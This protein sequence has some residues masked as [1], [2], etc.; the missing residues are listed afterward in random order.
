M[1]SPGMASPS[2]N[3]D[4][5]GAFG[6]FPP[7]G[8]D[9]NVGDERVRVGAVGAT[10][11]DV[12]QRHEVLK[13]IE[14]VARSWLALSLSQAPL[15]ASAL[16]QVYLSG[17]TSLA[18]H[19]SACSQDEDAEPH[20]GDE[21]TLRSYA[22]NLIQE[23]ITGV[24][25]SPAADLSGQGNGKN[26]A[27]IGRARGSIMWRYW[28][29]WAMH[30]GVDL[31]SIMKGSNFKERVNGMARVVLAERPGERE[32]R[33]VQ[34]S[35]ARAAERR[36]QREREA[37]RR[38]DA[39]ENKRLE[40]VRLR[41]LA[42]E[43][44][45]ARA[46]L[47]ARERA[48]PV[49]V[50]DKGRY[51][52]LQHKRAEVV[53][54]EFT[55]LGDLNGCGD[56]QGGE[57]ADSDDPASGE[58]EEEAEVGE[59]EAEAW[60]REL[61]EVVELAH[62]SLRRLEASVQAVHCPQPGHAR[63]H[64]RP[65]SRHDTHGSSPAQ[66]S[67]SSP[68]QPSA[69]SAE[70]G[71]NTVVAMVVEDMGVLAAVILRVLDAMTNRQ[72][73]STGG[74]GGGG[75]GNT[76]SLAHG[77]D[78]VACHFGA[79]WAD[80]EGTCEDQ[81]IGDMRG[82]QGLE[83][84]LEA[85]KASNCS[86]AWQNGVMADQVTEAGAEAM[87][88]VKATEFVHAGLACLVGSVFDS[89][90]ACP[91]VGVRAMREASE[92]WA[93]LCVSGPC[94]VS[95]ALVHLVLVHKEHAL[96]A[97]SGIFCQPR[98]KAQEE[99]ED[100][101]EKDGIQEGVIDAQCCVQGLCAEFLQEACRYHL[102]TWRGAQMV[103]E[104]HDCLCIALSRPWHAG[105]TAS[106]IVPAIQIVRLAVAISQH[107]A[108]ALGQGGPPQASLLA[109]R[110]ITAA[111]WLFGDAPSWSSGVGCAEESLVAG[112]VRSRGS[113]ALL[114]N[115]VGGGGRGAS[116]AWV[117]GVG[118]AS[119]QGTRVYLLIQLGLCVQLILRAP[120]PESLFA[121]VN[122]QWGAQ[123]GVADK[124][125]DAGEQREAWTVT[126]T[127]SSMGDLTNLVS[128]ELEDLTRMT[129]LSAD[130][131]VSQDG[132]MSSSHL[133]PKLHSGTVG[134][135]S[136]AA[137]G[138]EG[139]LRDGLSKG[140][141]SG[142]GSAGAGGL[143]EDVGAKDLAAWDSLDLEDKVRA[144]A[145]LLLVVLASEVRRCFVWQN[146]RRVSMESSLI[147]R[148]FS[149]E[150]CQEM[151]KRST[152]AIHVQTAWH[153]SPELALSL[154]QRY[155]YKAVL[156]Q[157]HWCAMRHPEPLVTLASS[158]S[159]F[160]RDRGHSLSALAVQLIATAYRASPCLYDSSTPSDTTLAHEALAHL[161]P[162]H[163]QPLLALCSPLRVGQAL[164]I[165][166]HSM[167]PFASSSEAANA[168]SAEAGFAGG[169]GG[170]TGGGPG[171]DVPVLVA[172][173]I[174][175]CVREE[176]AREGADGCAVFRCLPQLLQVSVTPLCMC[177]C[178]RERDCVCVLGACGG[179]CFRSIS[180][181]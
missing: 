130:R 13:S 148:P 105:R 96:E 104:M 139:S 10:A 40:R 112:L 35:L 21:E 5:R 172:A 81:E 1:R 164:A 138:A 50:A 36:Q 51:W 39:R 86:L 124:H 110:A 65:H 17:D 88:R 142:V 127:L 79:S 118:K 100:G 136:D 166:W 12:G 62:A 175:K 6:S 44:A 177:V 99:Q 61:E 64:V 131:D 163:H 84:W 60:A 74:A 2:S 66:R 116:G 120:K 47:L 68:A 111:L 58:D 59:T 34:R 73:G 20:G 151:C 108:V 57:S 173:F 157:L 18:Y 67:V 37:M 167:N 29:G 45:A 92:M 63:A 150:S 169:A 102:A 16:L 144:R 159:S 101:K 89:L 91:E 147:E 97:G 48:V 162:P 160:A 49:K 165:L 8:A 146:P 22:V 109:D 87:A 76:R 123:Q 26:G 72:P 106:G 133:S 98:P 11:G 85:R 25:P 119:G 77:R 46:L 93:W 90:C 32:E 78:W 125:G 156:E 115:W 141:G 75:G 43:Q 153:L 95:E 179:W 134:S 168:G 180:F 24:T 178:V 117:G 129:C 54:D 137:A 171:G 170:G 80:M 181:A 113:W 71:V 33:T 158:T 176:A 121:L 7:Q 41:A 94:W 27:G 132:L 30:G 103:Q 56:S 161:R 53:D 31:S 55:P 42:Q 122:V 149:V 114:P 4:W 3:G 14:D 140:V 107:A 143:R 70:R 38:R 52:G 154:Y 174:A 19:A 15:H 23:V 152:C 145:Q 69:A 83:R 155:P 135:R 126:G 82:L 28:G 9:A 128:A